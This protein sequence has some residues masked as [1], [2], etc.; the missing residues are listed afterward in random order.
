MAIAA[1]PGVKA[2]FK[3]VNSIDPDVVFDVV[4]WKEEDGSA[5]GLIVVPGFVDLYQPAHAP[6]APN[7][8]FAGYAYC[9]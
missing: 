7:Y 2:V 1:A 4:L 9:A 6:V 8:Y 5:V 3:D